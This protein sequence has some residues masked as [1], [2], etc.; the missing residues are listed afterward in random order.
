MTNATPHQSDC[1]VHNAPYKPAGPCD[2]GATNA[3]PSPETLREWADHNDAE[4]SYKCNPCV[5][6]SAYLRSQADRLTVDDT[7][8]RAAIERVRKAGWIDWDD[9]RLILGA[10]ERSM[11]THPSREWL[12]AAANSEDLAQSEA[13]AERLEKALREIVQESAFLS[14]AVQTEIERTAIRALAADPP[15]PEKEAG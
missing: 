13:R 11:T 4:L 6:I 12:V 7:E 3:T 10:A 8:L 15:K 9:L 14:P 1:A 5:D 2:C